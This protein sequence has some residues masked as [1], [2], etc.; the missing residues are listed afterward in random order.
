MAR[1]PLYKAAETEMIRR[2]E[3]GV[4]PVGTRLGNEFQLAEEFGVSQGTMR[5]ALMTLEAMGLLSR[6]PGRGTIVAEAS[7][8]RADGSPSG[9]LVTPD[10]TP[11]QFEIYRAKALT[12][13]ADSD[14][15]A[16]FGTARL[17]VC[18]RVLRLGGDR[19]ALDEIA[20]PEALAPALDEDAPV[21]LHDFLSAH[22]LSVARIE[23][24]LGV[25]MTTMGESVTLSCD[26][27]T[28]LMVLRR[29]ARG[30]DGAV[31]GRQVLRVADPDL[32]YR[33]GG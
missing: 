4:W 26:R 15:V 22:A 14:E 11:P 20:V 2:I 29:V 21:D 10:G 24:A 27:H 19:A 18:E 6:K 31:I 32:E 25:S 16:L 13:A 9:G 17:A 12:R 5:R 33:P 3:H 23:D 8:A 1:T 7:G 30:G 28:P